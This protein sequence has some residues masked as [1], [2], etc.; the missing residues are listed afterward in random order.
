MS[1]LKTIL[2]AQGGAT[3]NQ[4]ARQFGLDNK[5][6]Q[7]A[8]SQLI[9]A[10][11]GGVK[12]NVNQGGLDSLLSAL[13]KGNHQQYLD[14]PDRLSD[15]GTVL[16]G[17]AILGHLFGNKEVSREV[18]GRAA[19][20]TGINQSVL[21]KM[22][23]IVATMVMGSLGKQSSSGGSLGSLMSGGQQRGS[24]LES[25]LTSFLDAD[26]DGS[27]VDDLLGKLLK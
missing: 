16:D 22:L 25:M 2:E 19:T 9:P 17:N 1:L 12:N 15:Q 21:K 11:A 14:Q 26:G 27:I 10:L 13:N 8:L 7:S 23:P 6:T 18:A 24:G 4:L 5:Q 20:A 3:V